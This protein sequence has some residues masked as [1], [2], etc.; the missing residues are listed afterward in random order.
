VESYYQG[1]TEE[2]REKHNLLFVLY[3]CETWSL[4]LTEQHI[5]RVFENSV[6]RRIFGPKRDEVTEESRT[7][8]QP[9]KYKM[10]RH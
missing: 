10:D 6:L 4:T 2:L 1:K 8:R 9:Q 3:G 5:L 7:L